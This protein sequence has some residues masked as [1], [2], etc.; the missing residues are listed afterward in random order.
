MGPYGFGFAGLGSWNLAPTL[1]SVAG[2]AEP[3]SPVGNHQPVFFVHKVVACDT[4]DTPVIHEHPGWK[5]VPRREFDIAIRIIRVD[6][7]EPRHAVKPSSVVGFGL[8][9]AVL[10]WSDSAVVTA[11]TKVRDARDLLEIE[12]DLDEETTRHMVSGFVSHGRG[13]SGCDAV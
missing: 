2:Q 10:G 11:E 4:G 9:R 13:F 5:E 1:F 8:H 3:T 12:F 6:R 7:V